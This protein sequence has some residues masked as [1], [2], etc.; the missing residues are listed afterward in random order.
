MKAVRHC[1][2][3][4]RGL[5]MPVNKTGQRLNPDQHWTWIWRERGALRLT[6]CYV[7]R[8]HTHFATS[9]AAG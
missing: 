3:V 9:F 1:Q 7:S 2:V 6:P 8:F 4:A 5:I